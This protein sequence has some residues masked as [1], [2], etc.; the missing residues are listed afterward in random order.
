MFAFN[1][2]AMDVVKH[3]R[4][5]PC[6]DFGSALRS[7]VDTVFD[8]MNT[9][10]NDDHKKVFMQNAMRVLY[11]TEDVDPIFAVNEGIEQSLIDSLNV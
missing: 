8:A 3:Y 1:G 11:N 7:Y 6:N 2:S 10:D 4:K 9:L 5:T